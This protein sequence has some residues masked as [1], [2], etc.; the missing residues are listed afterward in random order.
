MHRE[1]GQQFAVKFVDIAKF[2]A[3]PGLSVEGGCFYILVENVSELSPLRFKAYVSVFNVLFYV[4][5]FCNRFIHCT[6]LVLKYMLVRPIRRQAAQ[7]TE[8]VPQ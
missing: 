3:V 1:T 8:R 5:P 2:T 6:L 7:V 4:L